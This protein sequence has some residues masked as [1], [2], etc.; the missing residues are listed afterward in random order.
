MDISVNTIE[1]KYEKDEETAVMNIEVIKAPVHLNYSSAV[2]SSLTTR[3]RRTDT[4]ARQVRRKSIG[5]NSIKL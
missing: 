2:K 1:V 5:H 3:T 4:R